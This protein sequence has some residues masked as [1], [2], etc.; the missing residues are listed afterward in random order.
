MP[1][2]QTRLL[3][4]VLAAVMAVGVT[5]CA[6][7]T[8]RTNAGTQL[9][10]SAAPAGPLVD[11]RLAFGLRYP[12]GTRTPGPDSALDERLNTSLQ[13]TRHACI[14]G[15]YEHATLPGAEAFPALD[16]RLHAIG[17]RVSNVKPDTYLVSRDFDVFALYA[18]GNTVSLCETR[19]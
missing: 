11:S 6:P 3:L 17:Y 14:E 18:D 15:R 8:G 16:E 2:R 9:Q 4:P 10:L 1:L 12:D 7:A 19:W 5:S 13:G